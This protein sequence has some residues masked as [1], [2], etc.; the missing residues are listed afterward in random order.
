MS[1][2]S[3]EKRAA[4]AIR[5]LQTDLQESELRQQEQTA[6]LE[7]QKRAQKLATYFLK[8]GHITLEKFEDTVADFCEQPSE[9]LD[10][11]EKA[12]AMTENGNG[13][14][15]GKVAEDVAS[16]SLSPEDRFIQRALLDDD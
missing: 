10:V 2:Q 8:I 6:Q 7:H 4:L 11:I 15:L 16:I 13:S 5:A 9:Q 12:A 14:F 3:L 1:E